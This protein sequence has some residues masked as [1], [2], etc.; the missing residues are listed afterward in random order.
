[1][2]F[3]KSI[4]IG[5]A[6]IISTICVQSATFAEEV[7]LSQLPGARIDSNWFRYINSRFGVAIDIPT[8]GYHYAVPEN[9][10]GLT[11]TSNNGAVVITV[12]A[13]W[14]VS[15]LDGADNDVPKSISQIFDNAVAETIQKGGTVA[16][17]V[18]KDEFYVISGY[19]RDNTYYER[20]IISPRC[21]AIYNKFRIFHPKAIER[22]LDGLV[23]RISKS[24]RA[25]CQGEEG[26]AIIN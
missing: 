8:R 6:T 15:V 11:L 22:S 25:T 7:S 10:S 21:S 17:S 23:T 12:G 1:M 26:A 3:G 14:V 2:R 16:Y 4:G 24:L 20:M 18:K 5:V 9:G 13:H 19:F